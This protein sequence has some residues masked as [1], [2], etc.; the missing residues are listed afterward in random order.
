MARPT[1]YDRQNSFRLYS[2]QYPDE[3]HNGTYLDTEFDAVKLALDETQDNLALI[4]G[5][6]GRLAAASVGRAQLD[7]SITI[8]FESPTPWATGTSYLAN[9]STVFKDSKFYTCLVDHTSGVFADDLSAGDWL[10]VADLSIAAAL[11]DGSVT[12]AKL[13][14]AAITTGKI[15]D[16]AVTMAKIATS[17]V[18]TAK[19][20]DSNVTTAKLANSGVTYSKIQDVSATDRILGRMTAGAGVIEEIPCTS[21]ARDLL[22]G[23]TASAQRTTLGLSAAVCTITRQVFTSSGTYTKPAG[24][25]YVEVEVIGG[26][27][28]GAGSDGTAGS[29]GGDSAFGTIAS[30][31]GGAGASGT[32]NALGAGGSGSNGDV[33]LTG[34]SGLPGI[35]SGVGGGHGGAARGAYGGAGGVSRVATVGLD[36]KTYGGGGAGGCFGSGDSGAGGGAGGMARRLVV[37]AS[38]T[39]T[40]A[41]TVGAGGAGGV[42][43]GVNGSAGAAGVVVVTTYINSQ[44]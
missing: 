20:A 41:V 11:D 23:S 43:S 26:G 2:A 35:G 40:V 10:L 13:A 15:N 22:A 27:G 8:G 7:S 39:A 31:T 21:Q 17:A 29:A 25:Q 6:D 18:T 32:G 33:N 14:D 42:G 30:A 3:P 36:G 1:T 37:A 24:T 28:G 4:Q 12:T 5:A 19:I 9:I 38:V 44:V 34:G 16:V